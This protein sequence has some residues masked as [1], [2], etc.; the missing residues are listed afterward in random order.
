MENIFNNQTTNI[1]FLLIIQSIYYAYYCRCKVLVKYLMPPYTQLKQNTSSRPIGQGH[2]WACPK[3]RNYALFFKQ[4]VGGQGITRGAKCRAY[5]SVTWSQVLSVHAWSRSGRQ[6][7][8]HHHH[9]Y[10][11]SKAWRWTP[12]CSQHVTT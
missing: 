12:Q 4:Q 3:L 10:D 1:Y 2:F 11:S 6:Y 9:H 8:P 5:K 7:H